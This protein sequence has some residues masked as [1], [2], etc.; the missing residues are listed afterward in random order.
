[1][2]HID[3]ANLISKSTQEEKAYIIGINKNDY[4]NALSRQKEG[5]KITHIQELKRVVWS[6]T[7]LL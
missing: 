5:V 3:K 7:S 2:H 6:V 1:M 4:K